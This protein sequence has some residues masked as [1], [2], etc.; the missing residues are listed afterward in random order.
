MPSPLQRHPGRPPTTEALPFLRQMGKYVLEG[1]IGRGGMGV[2]YLAQDR[3][4]ERKV[5]IKILHPAWVNDSLFVDLF[6]RE[7]LSIASLNHPNILRIHAFEQVEEQWIIEME[8]APHGSLEEMLGRGSIARS[9]MLAISNEVLS[10]LAACHTKGMVHRDIKPSNLLLA[11]DGRILISDFGLAAAHLGAGT[12]IAR[13]R[14]SMFFGTPR[15][16]PPEAWNGAKPAPTWDVYSVGVVLYEAVTGSAP[17]EA[18]TTAEFVRNICT[19]PSPSVEALENKIPTDFAHF[20]IRLISR[21]PEERPRNASEALEVLRTTSSFQALHSQMDLTPLRKERIYTLQS[22]ASPDRVGAATRPMQQLWKAHKRPSVLTQSAKRVVLIFLLA[23]LVTLAGILFLSSGWFFG[24]SSL[25]APEARVS[26]PAENPNEPVE[27]SKPVWNPASSIPEFLRVVNQ[28]IVYSATT[29]ETGRALWAYSPH[30]A[31]NVLLWDIPKGSESADFQLGQSVSVNDKLYFVV[32]V[33]DNPIRIAYT[34]GTP[35]GTGVL[36]ETPAGASF[37]FR[38][39]GASPSAI[40]Y[41]S[42]NPWSPSGLWISQGPTASPQRILENFLPTEMAYT[43]SGKIFLLDSPGFTINVL[44]EHTHTLI[45]SLHVS[46]AGLAKW[47][48]GIIFALA[49]ENGFQEGIYTWNGDSTGPKLLANLITGMYGSTASLQYIE[50]KHGVIFSGGTE[51]TGVELWFTQG[52]QE[53]TGLVRDINPGPMSSD[54]F[55]FTLAGDYVYFCATTAETGMELWKTDGTPEGT[56]LVKDIYPG[57][58]SSTPYSLCAL[59]DAL[60]FSARDEKH[61]EELWRTQGT[62]ETTRLVKDIFLGP[63]SS[64][65]YGTIALSDT[66]Y[67]SARDS[68]HGEELWGSDGTDENTRLILNLNTA[69]ESEALAAGLMLRAGT[70]TYLVI[71]DT[72]YGTELFVVG[73]RESEPHLVRD[74]LPGRLGS[75]PRLLAEQGTRVYFSADDGISGRELWVTEGTSATTLRLSDIAGGTASSSPRDLV[76]LGDNRAAFVAADGDNRDAL[77]LL[78]TPTTIQRLSLGIYENKIRRINHLTVEGSRLV[79]SAETNEG[80][81]FLV[82]DGHEPTL[83]TPARTDGNAG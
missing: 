22:I 50:Y 4:L 58:L 48:E 51:E 37:I 78:V 6:R 13:N 73:A 79:F 10:G 52:T 30:T 24:K 19:G 53:T 72:G 71:D 29:P 5:A 18:Y 1:E 38:L 25:I 46:T 60:Y 33:R 35:D 77:Y 63:E 75:A 61:G 80:T 16:A 44:E 66:L 49:G 82:H 40:Y 32:Q 43:P 47:R 64:M 65:P 57:S 81:L 9:Q 14:S 12:S 83:L 17:Y 15:Y 45:Q 55:R 21:E 34:D 23:L 36:L 59:K 39:L 11:E 56:R 26:S 27:S 28:T 8:Y 3:L 74:I 41:S 31:T 70:K 42:S 68:I 20:V 67:F 54:P 69:E 7:A 2:V 76:L 62:E